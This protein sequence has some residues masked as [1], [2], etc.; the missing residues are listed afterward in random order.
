M[1]GRWCR[2]AGTHRDR[3]D[4]TQRVLLPQIWGLDL[5]HLKFPPPSVLSLW[6]SVVPSRSQVSCLPPEVTALGGEWAEV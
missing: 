1:A 2:W 6:V 5:W 4:E 3:L